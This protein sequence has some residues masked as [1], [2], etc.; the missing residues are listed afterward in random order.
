MTIATTGSGSS[1]SSLNGNSR[2]DDL[3]SKVKGSTITKDKLRDEVFNVLL[4]D[5][6]ESPSEGKWYIFEYDPKKNLI[7]EKISNYSQK[8]KESQPSQIKT[9]GSTFKN[10]KDKKAWE[11]I[12]NS[13]G[14]LREL[15]QTINLV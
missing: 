6:V 5:A 4:D 9:C 14:N 15:V 11:L 12:K 10:P 13:N 1:N 2:F 8:K 3:I 7:K